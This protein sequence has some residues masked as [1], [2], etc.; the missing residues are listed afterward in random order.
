[1]VTRPEPRTPTLALALLLSSLLACKMFKKGEEEELPTVPSATAAPTVTQT[2]PP[3]AEEPKPADTPLKLGDVKRFSDKEKKVE[4][5]VKVLEAEVNV[6]NEPDVKA[7]HV[8]E[9]NKNIFVSRLA[10]LSSPR[11][12]ST[13]RGFGWESSRLKTART[14]SAPPRRPCGAFW[15]NGRGAITARSAGAERNI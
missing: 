11:L 6:F 3:P 12:S 13:R 2:A 7:P 9:L 10:T 5:V 15:S 4:G 8:A 1:M 14:F